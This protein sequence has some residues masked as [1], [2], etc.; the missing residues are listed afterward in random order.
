MWKLFTG[1]LTEEIYPYMKTIGIFLVEKKGCQRKLRETKFQLLTDEMVL[2]DDKKMHAN[3]VMVC[4]DYRKAW[5]KVPHSWIKKYME[6]STPMNKLWTSGR[7]LTSA[8][9]ELR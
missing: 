2:T 9:Q 7:Q 1:A 8:E 3:L 6:L 5:D 4:I